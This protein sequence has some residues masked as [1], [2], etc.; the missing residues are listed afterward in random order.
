M[1][2]QSSEPGLVGRIADDMSGPLSSE[3][4]CPNSLTSGAEL[5]AT[6]TTAFF[7]TNAP[8]NVTCTNFT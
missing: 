6:N 1:L 4:P 3:F 8:G 5:N 2:L 7:M